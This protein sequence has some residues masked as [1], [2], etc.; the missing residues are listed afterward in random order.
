M[1]FV[2]W[3]FMAYLLGSLPFGLIVS[4]IFCG[5]DPRT[6]GSGNVG[7]TNVGRLCGF[8]YGVIALALDLAKGFAPVAMALTFS[9]SWLFLSLTALA[10]VVGHMYSAF[11]SGRGGKGVATTI[12]VFL[13]LT[14]VSLIVAVVLCVATIALTGFVSMGSLVLG[15]SLP[16]LMVLSGNFSYLPVAFVITLMIFWKHRENIAR[17]ATGE[18]KTWRKGKTA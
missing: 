7:A 14:P 10:A 13:A 18:E 15:A 16:V 9:D 4:R 8:K 11:L 5:H 3:I 2:F 1:L 17:L 6:A 12:G